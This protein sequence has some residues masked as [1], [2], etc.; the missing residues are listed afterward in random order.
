MPI[1]VT[2]EAVEQ[3]IE[4]EHRLEVVRTGI[5]VVTLICEGMDPEAV[6]QLMDLVD[7]KGADEVRRYVR[8]WKA[9]TKDVRR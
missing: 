9:I 4:A 1:V 5:E 2:G 7:L 6:E 3:A 8:N